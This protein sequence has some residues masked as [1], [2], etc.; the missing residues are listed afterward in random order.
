MGMTRFHG[1]YVAAFAVA[2]S[3]LAAYAQGLPAEGGPIVEPA[4]PSVEL[5]AT[6]TENLSVALDL[7][8]VMRV[9]EEATTLVIGNPAIADATIRRNGLIVVTG[10]SY[11]TT[12]LIALN[13]D[14]VQLRELMIHVTAPEKRTLTVLRGGA[15]ETWSCSPRCE[16][17]VTLGDNP[18]YFGA[19]S[20][21]I[22]SRNGL[23]GQR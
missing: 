10:K 13:R 17:T 3:G 1:V 2:A 21:Q 5:V 4:E 12:N 19:S 22:G 11:G 15:R 8:T 9:P 16:Q 18:D 20:A 14:G 6:P 23:A 7:A